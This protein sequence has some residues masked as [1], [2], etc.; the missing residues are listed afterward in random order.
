MDKSKKS[1]PHVPAHLYAGHRSLTERHLANLRQNQK[2]KQW[3]HSNLGPTF[4]DFYYYTSLT[5][6]SS[7]K[8]LTLDV[9]QNG[10]KVS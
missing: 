8:G 10:A 6:Q 7:I 4:T 1:C 3:L 2:Q 9:C 5:P